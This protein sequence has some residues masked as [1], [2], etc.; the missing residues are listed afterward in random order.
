M[1][2]VEQNFSPFL[3]N[4]QNETHTDILDTKLLSVLLI[5]NRALISKYDFMRIV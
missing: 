5:V 4:I 1:A 2:E 3:Y